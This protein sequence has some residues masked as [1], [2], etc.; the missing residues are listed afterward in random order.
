MTLPEDSLTVDGDRVRQRRTEL[1]LS[2]REV[3]KQV[4]CS[5]SVLRRIERSSGPVTVPIGLP[6]R[7]ARVLACDTAW[8]TGS[9]KSTDDDDAAVLGAALARSPNQLLSFTGL[10]TGLGWA[11]SRLDLAL[12]ELAER[13]VGT[14]MVVAASA[15]GVGVRPAAQDRAASATAAALQHSW[16]RDGLRRNE[17]AMLHAVWRGE[18]LPNDIGNAGQVTLR[19]LINSGVLTVGTG[20]RCLARATPT[21]EV[22]Y[23]LHVSLTAEP[24]TVALELTERRNARRLPWLIPQEEDTS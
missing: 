7:L 23:S 12:A 3:V 19:K 8:I 14:G 15:R 2:V 17:A 10:C 20:D 21:A 9:D 16:R 24:R 6:P 1:G 22:T 13:L 11:P 4:G 18:R 5:E